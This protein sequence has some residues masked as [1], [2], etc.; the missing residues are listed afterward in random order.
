MKIAASTVYQRIFLSPCSPSPSDK[1]NLLME[2]R[3]SLWCVYTIEQLKWM[4]EKF[5]QDILDKFVPSKAAIS[6]F[7]LDVFA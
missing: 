6:A 3:H 2:K 1:L 7:L 5:V 4:L